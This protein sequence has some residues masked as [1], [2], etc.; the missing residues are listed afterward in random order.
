MCKAL[1]GT[2]GDWKGSLPAQVG[3]FKD[4]GP[5][6]PLCSHIQQGVSTAKGRQESQEKPLAAHACVSRYYHI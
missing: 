5:P 2:D 1:L 3:D 6:R 4:S